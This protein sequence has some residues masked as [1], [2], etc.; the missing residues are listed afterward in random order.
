MKLLYCGVVVVGMTIAFDWLTRTG[1]LYAGAVPMAFGLIATLCWLDPRW[2]TGA[3]AVVGG[4]RLSLVFLM[5]GNIV[6]LPVIA[7]VCV[8]SVLGVFKS[9]WF[10][11]AVWF[12]HPVW[13]MLPR[14]LPAALHE[15]PSACLLSDVIVGCYLVWAIRTGRVAALLQGT[16][17]R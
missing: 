3:W 12:G 2:Q 7:I 4:W 15:L 5:T 16:R 11:V 13:D 6:E 10:L 17:D 1:N 9:P 8:L 14:S